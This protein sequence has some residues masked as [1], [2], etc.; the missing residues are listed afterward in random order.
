MEP[1]SVS[2]HDGD[3]DGEQAI[4]YVHATLHDR[5]VGGLMGATGLH[6]QEA[7]LLDLR[8][9]EPLVVDGGDLAD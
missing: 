1:I 3:G 4:L 2:G 8:A 6:S 9:P 5:V 7:G